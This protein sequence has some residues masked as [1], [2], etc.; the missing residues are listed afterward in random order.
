MLEKKL[1][2]EL[3]KTYKLALPIIISQLG[4][5]LMS[6]VDN[7]MVGRLLGAT[8]LGAAGIA[9]SLAFLISSLAIGG[10]AVIAPMVSKSLAE[11]NT[12]KLAA[13]FSNTVLLAFLLS[14]A[15][16]LVGYF[17]LKY[18]YILGQKPIIEELAIPF[19]LLIFHNPLTHSIK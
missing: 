11:K 4:V 19:F 9:N 8:S 17:L 14:V 16:S 1:K 18:F 13:L 10:M 2:I 3:G 6:T 15:L 7:V 5:I 12:K